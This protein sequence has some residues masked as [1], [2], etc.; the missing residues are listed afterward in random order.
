MK[1]NNYTSR[2]VIIMAVSFSAVN[3]GPA[4]SADWDHVIAVIGKN[5]ASP[6]DQELKRG[7]EVFNQKIKTLGFECKF[8]DY[9]DSE[10]KR[11]VILLNLQSV[12]V[13][14]IALDPY[15]SPGTLHNVLNRLQQSGTPVITLQNDLD[16]PDRALRRTVVVSSKPS[17]LDK[18]FDLGLNVPRIA[19]NLVKGASFSESTQTNSE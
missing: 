3:Q 19:A 5:L 17:D 9:G 12:N 1:A 13:A 8:Y 2:A 11:E 10:V 4:I 16:P 14:A 15:P 7:C 6:Y 18:A